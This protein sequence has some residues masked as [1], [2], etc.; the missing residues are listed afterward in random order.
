MLTRAS[1]KE[2]ECELARRLYQPSAAVFVTQSDTQKRM[3]AIAKR[4]LAASNLQIAYLQIFSNVEIRQSKR[5]F[6][7]DARRRRVIAALTVSCTEFCEHLKIS[8]KNEQE[9]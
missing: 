4:V 9:C 7:R 2:S 3:S 1:E 8:K 6:Q 5:E